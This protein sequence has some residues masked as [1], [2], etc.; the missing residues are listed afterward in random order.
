MNTLTKRLWKCISYCF[1]FRKKKPNDNAVEEIEIKQESLEKQPIEA[2]SERETSYEVN[3]ERETTI[4]ANSE[5]ETSNEVNIE[6]ETTI[7]ANSEIETS[8]EVNIERETT[9]EAK[10]K[11][12]TAKKPN[13][14]PER[15][16]LYCDECV[17]RQ[18]RCFKDQV[19]TAVAVSNVPAPG[20]LLVY[21][22]N[23]S[24]LG[25]KNLKMT[26]HRE[27]IS[28]NNKN[29]FWTDYNVFTDFERGLISR[30]WVK[31]IAPTFNAGP[32]ETIFCD[33]TYGHKIISLYDIQPSLLLSR[34]I[35]QLPLL[36][37]DQIT[38]HF[39]SVHFTSKVSQLQ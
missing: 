37:E 12:E 11:S 28:Y 3:S 18:K 36:K 23:I 14:S 33:P 19:K 29:I 7:E 21:V 39:Y 31:K 16:K 32:K 26:L 25:E 17:S 38:N 4:E 2:N 1:P 9:I 30:G 34:N 24:I 6:R 8:N 35:I 13:V 5:I 10:R 27:S 20:I 15:D 22:V